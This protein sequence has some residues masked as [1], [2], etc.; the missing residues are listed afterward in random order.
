MFST[1]K[2]CLFHN[3]SNHS[4]KFIFQPL[5]VSALYRM[6]QHT[7]DRAMEGYKD[8]SEARQ[9]GI[10][11]AAG[12]RALHQHSLR[13]NLPAPPGHSEH[14]STTLKRK[15][16]RERRAPQML[17][18]LF[19]EPLCL[20]FERKPLTSWISFPDKSKTT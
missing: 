5:S 9:R 17:L 18:P 12:E 6:P 4:R 11:R 10:G 7:E 14:N 19:T 13:N 3:A 1:D 8:G 15:L 20:H 16:Q 2:E